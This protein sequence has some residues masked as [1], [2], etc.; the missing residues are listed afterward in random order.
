[1][2]IIILFIM[3]VDLSCFNTEV[4]GQHCYKVI[5]MRYVSFVKK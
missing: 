2:Q 3:L 5:F 4:S 1:M